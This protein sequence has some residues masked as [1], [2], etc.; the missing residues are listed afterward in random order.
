RVELKRLE[1]VAES[2]KG[3]FP[4]PD[5]TPIEGW[6]VNYK[7][8]KATL[9]DVQRDKLK[10]G[11]DRH[12][13]IVDPVNR[14]LYEF[15]QLKKTGAGWEA[16]QASIFDLKSNKMRPEEWT[17]TDAAGLPIFPAVVRYDELKRGLVEH[18][19]RVTVVK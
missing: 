6:P 2:D 19:L 3:P 16:A 4:I 12:A 14:M 17:S 7:D 9:D 8:K 1:Y 15:Y 13:L 18:A 10:E 5:I 11:G